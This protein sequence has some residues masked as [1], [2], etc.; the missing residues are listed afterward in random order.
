MLLLNHIAI[1]VSSKVG[2][3]FYKQ[4]GFEEKFREIRP[5]AHDE[6]IYLSNGITAL[7][8]YMTQ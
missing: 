6:L 7:E 2:V 1:I 5:T 8:I 4:L 3:D